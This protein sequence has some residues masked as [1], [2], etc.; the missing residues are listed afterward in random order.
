MPTRTDRAGDLAIALDALSPAVETPEGFLKVEGRAT[1]SGVFTYLRRDGITVRELRPPEEVNDPRSLASLGGKPFTLNHPPCK[2]TPDNVQQYSVGTVGND[3]VTLGGFVRIRGDVHVREAIDA[4]RT[5][6]RELSNGYNCDIEIKG[7]LWNKTDR[8][9]AFDDLGPL[10]P[11]PEGFKRFDAVQ[12][13]IRYNHVA[14]VRDGTGR[15]GRDCVFRV[16][17]ADPDQDHAEQIPVPSGDT[18][19][20]SAGAKK[21]ASIVIDGTTFDD[22]D[23]ALAE[24]VTAL[25][26]RLEAG[27]QALEATSAE[28]DAAQEMAEGEGERMDSML[29]EFTKRQSSRLALEQL[30]QPHMG[31]LRCDGLSDREVRL[32]AVKGVTGKDMKEKDDA[33]L[34]VFTDITLANAVTRADS[35][36]ADRDALTVVGAIPP[37]K[38]SKTSKATQR[39]E[40]V[41]SVAKKSADRYAPKGA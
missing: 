10:G 25:M 19:T 24:A 13:L 28:R 7:G 41:A 20:P 21:M 39:A 8:T 12:R 33:Y 2:L 23:D 3:I 5:T 38:G 30:C 16:D 40:H 18:S 17:A 31:E 6:H 32:A 15:A 34:A 29:A 14:I 22:V 37:A 35:V 27:K 4:A 26:D 11:E 9:Y 1:K 36:D